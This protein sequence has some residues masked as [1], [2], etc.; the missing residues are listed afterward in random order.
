MIRV[1]GMYNFDWDKDYGITGCGVFKRKFLHK[2]Q[3]TQRKLFNF[4]FWI[5]GKL[6]KQ[7]IILVIKTS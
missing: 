5:N 3:H 2:N 7:G 1:L 4:E 6:S